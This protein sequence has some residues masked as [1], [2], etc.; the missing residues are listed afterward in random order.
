MCNIHLG[1]TYR[2]LQVQQTRLF[3][4]WMKKK[5]FAVDKYSDVNN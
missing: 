5:G 1:I 2:W 3:V 4:A